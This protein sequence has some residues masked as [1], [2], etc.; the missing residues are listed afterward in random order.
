M[1]RSV[2]RTG[3]PTSLGII[4]SEELSFLIIYSPHT[5]LKRPAGSRPGLL[6]FHG[7]LSVSAN[8]RGLATSSRQA[9]SALSPSG[10]AVEVA[11]V[12]SVRIVVA[13]H[14]A[15]A[16][17]FAVLVTVAVASVV[18]LVGIAVR[19]VLFVLKTVALFRIAATGL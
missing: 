19:I 17:R 12:G 1:N 15:L 11:L 3:G 14:E 16:E 2:R 9:G 4:R 5:P 13:Q 6:L 18:A 8:E 10:S 7:E